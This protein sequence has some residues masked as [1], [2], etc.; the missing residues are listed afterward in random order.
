[1]AIVAYTMT[2]VHLVLTESIDATVMW[3]SDRV[4]VQGDYVTFTLIHPVIPTADNSVQVTKILTCSEHQYLRK[5][6][7]QWFCGDV[8]IGDSRTHAING[9]ALEQFTWNGPI[10]AGK[11]FVTGN[12]EH[13][14]DS[15]YWGFIDSEKLKTVNK[16]F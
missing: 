4:P 8:K 2:K 1:M 15:R 12:G 13:S 9:D 10:P 16:V 5:D 6:K 11:R 7:M 3:P 14:F